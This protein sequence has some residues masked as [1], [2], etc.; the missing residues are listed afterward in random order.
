M[1]AQ[2]ES[3]S[4]GAGAAQELP[5][6][7]LGVGGF[8]GRAETRTRT[9]TWTWTSPS[10]GARQVNSPVAEGAFLLSFL[11]VL[12]ALG[13]GCPEMEGW[14]PGDPAVAAWAAA[15]QCLPLSEAAILGVWVQSLQYLAFP[16]L[17]AALSPPAG[18]VKNPI[19]RP[20][21]ASFC[22]LSCTPC[23]KKTACVCVHRA[24]VGSQPR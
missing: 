15:G 13:K 22:C 9:W 6:G 5:L 12:R 19:P 2:P 23:K 10:P 11:T 18:S 1:H 14:P 20:R 3:E 7:L 16:C 24:N 8:A 17:V 21:S 4:P